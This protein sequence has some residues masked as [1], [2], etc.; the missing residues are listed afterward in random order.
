MTS[1]LDDDQKGPVSL[2]AELLNDVRFISRLLAVSPGLV[3]LYDLAGTRPLFANGNL[4]RSIGLTPEMGS[5]AG[6]ALPPPVVHP[7]DAGVVRDHQ[8]RLAVAS[9][10]EVLSLEFRLFHADGRWHWMRAREVVYER[11]ADGVPTR[12][13]GTAEDVTTEHDARVALQASEDMFSR[14]FRLSPDSINITRLEDGVYLDV[15][16]GFLQMTAY[17]REEV[18][19]Q[20]STSAG[21]GL[22]VRDEDRAR[23]VAG[24]KATGEVT[25]LEALFRRK[26][27]SVLHGLMSARVIELNGEAAV[28]T[29]TRDITERKRAEEQ[30]RR[31]AEELDSFFQTNLDMLCVASPEG[32]F[33]RLNQEW[34]ATLG[35]PLRNLLGAN[36][37]DL[38]HP[39]DLPATLEAMV[40]LAEQKEVTNFV[41]RFRHRDGSYRWLEWRSKPCGGVVHAAAR[42]ITERIRNEEA[43]TEAAAFSQQVISSAQEG[44]LVRDREGRIVVFNPFMANLLGIDEREPLGRPMEQGPPFLEQVGL[45]DGFRRALQ[46]E[47]VHLPP[48]RWEMP[49]GRSGWA[50]S[51]Q[52]PLIGAKGEIIG[53]IETVTDLTELHQAQEQKAQLEAELH[54]AQKLESLGSLAGGIAHDMNNVLAAI[55]A[56]TETLKLVC[57]DQGP[58][59]K[60]LETIEKATTRGRNLVKSLTNFARKDMREPELLDLN[61]LVREEGELLRRTTL[62]KVDLVLDLDPELPPVLGERGALGSALMNLCVNAVDAMARGGA[63]TIRTRVRPDAQAELAVL[64][65]GEGMSP[66]V[67]ARA[68]EPFFTTKPHGKGTGLGLAMVYATAKAHGGSVSI[69]SQPGKGTTVVLCLPSTGRPGTASPPAEA[70]PPASVPMDILLVDDDELIRASVPP[71]VEFFGH[72]VVTAEGGEEALAHLQTGRRFDLVI[73]DLN[74]PGMD[75]LETLRRLRRLRPDLPVLLATGRLDDATIN[76]LR[77][78]GKALGIF[79][80]FSMAELDLKFKV[81]ETLRHRAVSP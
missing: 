15:N 54:Q 35:Y 77:K 58:A 26:D 66:E 55:Q 46:G 20:P 48:Y 65:T 41:N 8:A 53:V 23:L 73:L 64:D 27:G 12:I 34:E 44:L 74:M 29:I 61:A 69:W 37:L 43:L 51:V 52:A 19:G 40:S 80:P 75:G 72:R 18:L 42:D 79:K 5:V 31:Q 62:Q 25:G 68:M 47:L 38:V 60:G 33:L 32:R 24:L 78:D 3:Y 2:R 39:D 28:L 7:D 10:A 56:V 45:I 11:G 81:L 14:A 9:D 36:Y 70:E 59:V 22:W 76:A 67:L 6:P 63:L 21:L 30:V 71:M 4:M 50:V 1:V 49:N 16:H 17:T 13:L 57:A